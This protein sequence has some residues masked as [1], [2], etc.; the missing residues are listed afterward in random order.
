MK[1]HFPD[2]VAHINLSVL[3]E[4]LA[5]IRSRTKAP[6]LLFVV[7]SN[8]YGHGAVQI[9]R[10]AE[11]HVDYFGVATVDEGIELRMAGV[12]KPILVF[13][14]PG[15]QNAAAYGTHN[16]TATVSDVTHFSVL[17]DGTRYH[18]NVNTGM[19]RLGLAPDNLEEVRKLAVANQRLV[20]TGIYSHLATSDEPGSKEVVRQHQQFSDIRSQFAEI[21]TA[22]LLNSGGIAFYGDL[23]PFEMVRTGMLPYGFTPGKT[24]PDW[25]QPVLEWRSKVVQLRP[26]R[27]G[28]GVSY[29]HTWRAERDGWLATVPVGYS[30]GIPRALSNRLKVFIN[31]KQLPQ[32]GNVT[33]D[34]IM[35]Y[36]PEK[37][38]IVGEEVILL[39]GEAESAA[40]WAQ[41]ANSNL[42]EIFTRLSGERIHRSFSDY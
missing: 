24:Q 9:A 2:S 30:D 12:K 33:M 38:C 26:V 22:H 11:S 34:Y 8:A 4:N 23:E 6:Y 1:L 19:N 10:H 41:N 17:M 42:H 31:G 32:V 25:V 14:V 5:R 37:P 13:G 3:L 16:L 39:G 36:S 28:D 29:G 7:K 20:C 40:S 21:T 18:L 15:A 27:K 35:V